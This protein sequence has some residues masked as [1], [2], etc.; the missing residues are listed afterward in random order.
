MRGCYGNEIVQA[1][2]EVGRGD[3]EP[4][5]GEACPVAASR[6]LYETAKRADQ[7]A[8]RREYQ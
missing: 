2:G 3:P 6:P 8:T 5:T 1:P 7:P 4:R